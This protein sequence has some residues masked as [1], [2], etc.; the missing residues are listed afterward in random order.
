MRN[1]QTIQHFTRER[2][3]RRHTKPKQQ[4]S[5]KCQTKREVVDF[6]DSTCHRKS[7]QREALKQTTLLSGTKSL[8]GFYHNP[9]KPKNQNNLVIKKDRAKKIR[10][11]RI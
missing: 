3:R 5:E 7:G 10:S 8:I 2:E 9:C 11:L 6:T 1:K 4:Q